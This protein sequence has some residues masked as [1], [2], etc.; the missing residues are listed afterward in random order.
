MRHRIIALFSANMIV[1]LVAVTMIRTAP[2]AV[3]SMLT[4]DMIKLGL[5]MAGVSISP[6]SRLQLMDNHRQMHDYRLDTFSVRVHGGH[7]TIEGDTT[8]LN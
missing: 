3:T 6:G 4:A 8:Q 5:M 2:A 7:F 1:A